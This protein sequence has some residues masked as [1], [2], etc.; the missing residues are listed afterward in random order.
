MME[1]DRAVGVLVR[2]DSARRL[3]RLLFKNQE[4][5][6][7]E[8]GF[9]FDEGEAQCFEFLGGLF[10][11]HFVEG[12][13]GDARVFGAELE[14]VNFATGFE[15]GVD[16]LEHFGGVGELVIGIDEEDGIDGVFGE[17]DR[18]DGSEVGLDVGDFAFGGLGLEVVEHF[19]LDID[20]DDF[21]F[22]NER[23]DAE[24]V[25]TGAGTDIGDNRIGSEIEEGDGLGW[26]FFFFAVAAFQ[27]AYS[28]VSHN[29]GDFS[30]H[31]EFTDSGR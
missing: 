27:P 15:C 11:G 9:V 25:V 23:G 1:S 17:L 14:E 19:L 3:Y 29:L 28:W 12:F 4:M 7:W 18:I 31:E 10:G 16:G 6:P 8:V 13:D 5:L 22:G 30:A 24:A 20:R 2:V 21:A 26:G